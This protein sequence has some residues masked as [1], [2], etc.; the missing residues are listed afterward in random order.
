MIKIAYSV[1]RISL[2]LGYDICKR[3]TK[4][5][6]NKGRSKSLVSGTIW[7]IL[8]DDYLFS[9]DFQEREMI[10]PAVIPQKPP[11]ILT[12]PSSIVSDSIKVCGDTVQYWYIFTHM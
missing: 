7:K 12:K 6:H 1:Y 4:P 2:L 9:Q 11:I 8:T 10:I 5:G 3:N